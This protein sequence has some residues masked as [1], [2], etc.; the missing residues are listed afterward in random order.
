[1]FSSSIKLLMRTQ[2]R[3]S[4]YAISFSAR[5]QHLLQIEPNFV[6][7]AV[8]AI[9]FASKTRNPFAVVEPKDAAEEAEKKIRRKTPEVPKITLL[10]TKESMSI[11]TLEE[12]EKIAVGRKLRLVKIIDMDIRTKRP[13]YKL[14]TE[15]Q[16]LEE[17]LSEKKR[18][19]D[20][21]SGSVKGEKILMMSCRITEN[22]LLMKMHNAEKWL[23]K[24]FEVRVTISGPDKSLEEQENVFAEFEKRFKEKAKFVQK[25]TKGGD[26]K[27]QLM[28]LK[29][30][31]NEDVGKKR[32]TQKVI[33][34]EDDDE[35]LNEEVE[36]NKS[37]EAEIHKS[38]ES[39][40]ESTKHNILSKL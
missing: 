13:I 35:E 28:P 15:A 27:F 33:Q 40:S 17:E 1:M 24:N 25:R 26:L 20:K 36:I 30:A 4:L 19:K 11:C 7:C 18:A 14:M 6:K 3:R 22:D 16:Y 23:R 29:D 38:G 9:R 10:D 8:G 31:L 21:K 39:S 5:E 34:V 2:C 12:A 37:E 32:S